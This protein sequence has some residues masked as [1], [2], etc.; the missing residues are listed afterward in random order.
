MKGSSNQA[1]RNKFNAICNEFQSLS[2]Y[3]NLKLKTINSDIMRQCSE[4]L[5]VLNYMLTSTHSFRS[6]GIEVFVVEVESLLIDCIEPLKLSTK[7][8]TSDLKESDYYLIENI[9]NRLKEIPYFKFGTNFECKSN[10]EYIESF[11]SSSSRVD[12]KFSGL[13]D[14]YLNVGYSLKDDELTI[15]LITEIERLHSEYKA[16][17]AVSHYFAILGPS[18]SG[19]TQCAFTLANKMNIIYV[20][21]LSKSGDVDSIQPIHYLFSGFVKVFDECISL[22]KSSINYNDQ[23]I[24]H[25]NYPSRTLGLLYVLIRTRKLNMDLSAKDWLKKVIKIGNIVVPCLTTIEF[26]D[27]IGGKSMEIYSKL[28]N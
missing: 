19:K 10:I 28:I 25:L 3:F 15:K 26:K 22:D 20:N 16:D 2:N 4:W 7:E 17:K 5:R 9:Q 11:E 24:F 8:Y 12:S 23:K 14:D 27:K 21:F 6:F 13:L 18:L 1:P